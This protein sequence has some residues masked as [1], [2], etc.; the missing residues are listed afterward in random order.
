MDR[1]PLARALLG[2]EFVQHF[3]QTRQWEVAQ[4]N[5]GV[6]DWELQRYLELV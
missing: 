5:Q 3:V 6:T 4:F 2:T 1:S